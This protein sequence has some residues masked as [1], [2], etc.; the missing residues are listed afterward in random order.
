MSPLWL[1]AK[2][3]IM[4]EELEFCFDEATEQMSKSIDHLKHVLAKIRA[5]RANA[6]MLSSVMVDYYGA[7][8]PLS[9]VGNISTPDART[10]TISAWEKSMLDPIAKGVMVAN[11]GLN[12]QNNGEMIIISIPPLTEERRHDL[13]K[14]AKTEVEDCKV[15][16][17]NARK[18][19]NTTIKGLVKDGLSEDVGKD[20]ENKIQNMVT[21][22]TSKAEELLKV[23]EKEIMTI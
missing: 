1:T 18:T 4:S 20:A 9:Q 5:G 23:K 6:N 13:V 7:P 12:P 11:L 19:A 2:K 15:G 8:T 17:R 14:Q 21:T 3:N 22:F 10:L 16:L